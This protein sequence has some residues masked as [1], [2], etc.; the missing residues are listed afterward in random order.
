M[1]TKNKRTKVVHMRFYQQQ[2]RDQKL[3]GKKI[4]KVRRVGM[5]GRGQ[6]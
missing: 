6:C 5:N 1:P 4:T 2:T 3:K